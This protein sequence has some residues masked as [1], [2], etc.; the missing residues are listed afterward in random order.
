[1]GANEPELA[2]SADKL[3]HKTE[4]GLSRLT[5]RMA[6][7][8]TKRH[9]DVVAW[10]RWLADSIYPNGK[11][12]ERVLNIVQFIIDHGWGFTETLLEEIDILSEEM[13]EVAL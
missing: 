1:V 11:P 13:Q 4:Y 3:Q 10:I 7:T 8:R 9:E 5:K 12:Q 6:D 2:S